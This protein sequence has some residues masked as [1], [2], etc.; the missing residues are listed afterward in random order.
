VNLFLEYMVLQLNRFRIQQKRRKL[1]KVFLSRQLQFRWPP[2]PMPTV[3][4]N[5]F[6]TSSIEDYVDEHYGLQDK[7]LPFVRQTGKLNSSSVTLDFGCGFGTLATALINYGHDTGKYF[8]YDTNLRAID[9]CSSAFARVPHFNF[10]CPLVERT[11]NYVTNRR[12]ANARNAF[13]NHKVASPS[14]TSLKRLLGGEVLTCQFSLSVFTHM[15][16]EDAINSLRSFSEFTSKDTVFINTW[17]IVDDFARDAVQ[18]GR[19]DRELPIEVGGILTY[20]NANPLLCT[21]YPLE[22]LHDVYYKA[23]HKIEQIGYGS[24]AGRNNGVTYQDIVVSKLI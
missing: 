15:W 7:I 24:W 18:S 16:P 2:I 4:E 22:L 14:R 19:A 6:M 17:L 13:D 20:S 3:N 8:G 21:A 5:S 1:D 23:G 12:Y 11:T 10:Y 9:Y